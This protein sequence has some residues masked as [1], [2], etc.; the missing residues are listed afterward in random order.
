[1]GR[2]HRDYK[3]APTANPTKL[4]I[5]SVNN[6]STPKTGTPFPVVIQAQDSLGDPSNVT[7]TTGVSLSLQTPGSGTLGGTL[8]GTIAAGAN[9]ITLNVTYT[10]SETGLILT[11]SRTS[12]DPLSAANSAPFDVTWGAANA[13][14]FVVQPGNSVAGDAIPGFP[15]VV[16]RDNFGDVITSSTLNVTI[17]I[18]PG[19]GILSGTTTQNVGSGAATFSDLSIDSP[20]SGYKLYASSGEYK[21]AISTPFD[22]T[23]GPATKL[24]FTSQPKTGNAGS[25]IAGPPT[26]T[27]EDVLGNTATSSTAPVTL[28]LHDNLGQGVLSGTTTKNASSGVASFTDITIAQAGPSYTL[29]ASSP[30]LVGTMS[31][32]FSMLA[33]PGAAAPTYLYD[34]L[35]R[36]RAVV[37]PSGDTA[38]YTYDAVGNLLSIGRRNSSQVS[39]IDFFPKTGPAGTT[40]NI[41]GTGFSTTASQNTVR[42]NGALATVLSS[43]A[44]QVVVIVPSQA[45]TGPITVTNSNGSATSTD[46]F[47]LSSSSG[48]PTITNFTPSIG[49]V[50][51]AVTINGTNF[52]PLPTQNY[53]EFSMGRGSTTA[54]SATTI[55]ASVT[56][57]AA[58]GKISVVTPRGRGT[59]SADFFVAPSPYSAADVV[60]AERIPVGSSKTVTFATANKIALIIFEGVRGQRVTLLAN[61][62]TMTGTTY[63]AINRPDGQNVAF[64]W[65]PG[66]NFL[67]P[68]PLPFDGTYTIFINPQANTGSMTVTLYNVT[69]VTGSITP[70]GPT[71]SVTFTTPGQ[72]AKLTF[73]ATVGQ[74]FSVEVTQ[75]PIC[76]VSVA[77]LRPEGSPY[78]SSPGY[79]GDFFTPFATVPMAGT[80][81]LFIDP[82]SATGTLKVTLIGP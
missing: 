80:Q 36:L 13:L 40:V 52:I 35:G 6:G 56:T 28:T 22:V 23:P 25:P 5:V 72:N 71:V 51:T 18:Q 37:D 21:A 1:M 73:P 59:S 24:V 15:T 66:N 38:V 58:S 57:A 70:G 77:L 75:N 44:T 32:V 82:G 17:E 19:N 63:I 46:V 64:G 53:V 7:S 39:I 26:V 50:G 8:T 76:G 47:T 67:E 68:E 12:G 41:Q 14:E 3:A 10:K 31:N 55:A 78:Y 16:A 54:A 29:E 45:T 42:F 61:N 74:S 65:L 30:G 2:S 60:I 4:A 69:D 79:C 48:A 11:A 49:G 34:P 27:L 81:T 62:S 43:T 20:G 9:S 33:S